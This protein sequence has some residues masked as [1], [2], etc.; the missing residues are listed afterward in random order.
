MVYLWY[1]TRVE[2]LFSILLDCPFPGLL[3]TENS[4]FWGFV[5]SVLTGFQ[6]AG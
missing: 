1:L 6:V 2:Q 5:L 3:A 4:H